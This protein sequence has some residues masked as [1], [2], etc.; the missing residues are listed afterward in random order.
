VDAGLAYL[1]GQQAADGSWGDGRFR[2][3]LA[4]TG[5]AGRAFLAG[6]H[7]PGQGKY[8]PTLTKAIEFI[9]SH[10]GKQTPGF[11]HNPQTAE[12][13]PMYGHGFALLFL[14]EAHGSIRDQKLKERV[15][16]V[17][18]RAVKLTVEAQN[19]EGGWRYQPRPM[20]AD[21]VVTACQLQALAAVRDAGVAVRRG[22]LEQGVRYVLSCQ[23]LQGDGGF[24]YMKQGGGTGFA[25]S[26]AALMALYLAGAGKG[27]EAEKALDYLRP[28]RP[29]LPKADATHM[30]YYHGQYYAAQAMWKAGGT[31]WQK[32]YPAVRDELLKHTDR[33]RLKD[34]AETLWNDRT[35][36]PQYGTAMAL[37]VLQIPHQKLPS[38]IR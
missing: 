26:A 8:G 13:G 1:A 37:I 25:R 23:D 36:G 16:E 7:H 27:Q 3:N 24:R 28:H 18:G 34:G 2:G 12:H 4:I 29:G 20:D 31:D 6:G 15:T 32:W 21:V 30:H 19:K 33:R 22:V 38:L 10:E 11:L 14:A 5:L 9:L 35:V 17:L